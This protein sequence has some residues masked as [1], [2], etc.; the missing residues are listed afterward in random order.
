MYKSSVINRTPV[1]YSVICLH[2]TLVDLCSFLHH[3]RIDKHYGSVMIASQSV[4]DW[5]GISPK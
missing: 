5:V 2:L 1:N 4:V 3:S